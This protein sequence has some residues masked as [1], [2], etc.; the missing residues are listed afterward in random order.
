M[1]SPRFHRG[2]C[3]TDALEL[4][5]TRRCLEE[6]LGLAPGTPF[7]AAR[8]LDIVKAFMAK[9]AADPRSAKTVGPPAGAD[10]FF[11]LGRGH[12]H[13]GA[14]WY[15]EVENVVWLCGYGR[16]RS[17]DPDDVFQRFPELIAAGRLKPTEDDY[18]ALFE[19]HGHRFAE[20]VEQD[21]AALLER[22]RAVP[23]VEHRAV[24]GGDVRA[25]V[26]VEV[27]ETLEELH[28]AFSVA[29][30]DH[31]RPAVILR[32]ILPDAGFAEWELTATFPTRDLDVAAAEIA[33]RILR[34]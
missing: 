27:V 10:S 12:D 15:D 23:E 30:L 11:H 20:T 31:V 26:V 22:A 7:E 14:T 1:P 18:T 29:R 8:G 28:V 16:H 34:E 24:L 2:S 25:G 5:I 9:R 19:D 4:R 17:G 33:Y 6:D 32:A 3:L 21:A 13:R